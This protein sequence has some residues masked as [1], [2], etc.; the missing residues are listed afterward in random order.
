[1]AAAIVLTAVACG[2]ASRTSA[3]NPPHA[4]RRE[5]FLSDWHPAA[6]QACVRAAHPDSLPP[7]DALLDRDALLAIADGGARML[8]DSGYVLLSLKFDTAGTVTRARVIESSLADSTSNRLALA[9]LNSLRP[10]TSAKA[11]W[12]VRLRLDAGTPTRVRVGYAE[13]CHVAPMRDF[14]SELG[15]LMRGQTLTQEEMRWEMIVAPDGR[16]TSLM[17]LSATR[18]PQPIV[19]DMRV[20][21]SRYRMVPALDD[22]V[23]VEGVDTITIRLVGL[24]P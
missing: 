10:Q 18:L 1:M 9:V 24:Q 23:P 11:P 7:V 21:L 5:L 15:Y 14:G 6:L 13:R 20:Q 2:P 16:V 17:M 22:R 19:D 3:P 12:G 4:S 8:G